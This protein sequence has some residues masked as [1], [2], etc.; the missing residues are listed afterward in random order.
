MYAHTHNPRVSIT[1]VTQP[2]SLKESIPDSVPYWNTIPVEW[3]VCSCGVPSLVRGSSHVISI[4]DFQVVARNLWGQEDLV[5]QLYTVSIGWCEPP[6]DSS[7]L[8][9]VEVGR[10][11][12]TTASQ[13]NRDCPWVVQL[14]KLLFWDNRGVQP[15]Q[16]ILLIVLSV[17]LVVIEIL[18][19]AQP[20]FKIL[21]YTLK[22]RGKWLL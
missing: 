9:C 20:K 2:S 3:M 15:N 1:S 8:G 17:D 7:S 14:T 10:W 11:H 16:S 5:C 21:P 13:C 12:Q 19:S 4:N 18:L 6:N 22:G